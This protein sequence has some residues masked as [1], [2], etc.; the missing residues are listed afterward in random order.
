[1]YVPPSL[2][3]KNFYIVTFCITHWDTGD[4]TECFNMQGEYVV[5]HSGI[6]VCKMFPEHTNVKC[7]P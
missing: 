7:Q 1:V 3:G 6:L 2:C 4:V 5:E